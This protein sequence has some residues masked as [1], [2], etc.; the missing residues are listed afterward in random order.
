MQQLWRWK[1]NIL[2]IYSI[3]SVVLNNV[4]SKTVKDVRDG[5]FD[6][7]ILS[8][9]PQDAL[10]SETIINCQLSLP[11]TNYS[12]KRETVYYGNLIIASAT[13]KLNIR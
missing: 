8:K 10:K 1:H 7:K 3:N 4:D 11:N 13:T 12:R 5:L 9:L 6:V 2:S